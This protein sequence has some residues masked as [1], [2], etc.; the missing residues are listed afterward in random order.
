MPPLETGTWLDDLPDEKRPQEPTGQPVDT[1][2]WLDDLPDAKRPRQVAGE[3]QQ[4]M[5]VAR[6]GANLAEEPLGTFIARRSIPFYSTGRNVGEALGY[7]EARKRFAAGQQTDEDYRTVAEYERQQQLDQEREQTWGGSLAAGAAHLP[8]IVGEFAAGGAA[9][10]GA[11][12]AAPRA[13]GWLAPKVAEE[14]AAV[15]VPRLLSSEGL[16]AAA[17]ATPGY[18]GRTAALTPL[19]PSSYVDHWTQ[20]NV[21][22]GRDPLDVRGLPK[23]YGLGVMQ[24]AVLGAIGGVGQGYVKGAGVA[25]GLAR[26][27]IAGG[28]GATVAQPAADVL[29]YG[30]GLQTRYGTIQ[31]LVEGK[32]GDALRH[33]TVQ[34]L[35]F[36]AF[37]LAHEAGRRPP[38]APDPVMLAYQQKLQEMASRG[39]APG[40]AGEVLN[41][42]TDVLAKALEENPNLER[43]QARRAVE[44]M[45]A[46]PARE[47]GLEI[48]KGWPEHRG[49]TILPE[50][51]TPEQIEAA[52]RAGPTLPP[53]EP[54]G[55]NPF[56]RTPEGDL[57]IGPREGR[58]QAPEAPPG[59]EVPR[60]AP[61]ASPGQVGAPEGRQAA[62]EPAPFEGLSADEIQQLAQQLTGKKLRTAEGLAAALQ[63]HGLSEAGVRELADAFRPQ[64]SGP[65]GPDQSGPGRITSDLDET[66]KA[67]G[68]GP[69][70]REVPAAKSG[71]VESGSNW[72]EAFK[73]A[74]PDATPG[75]GG[76]LKG[77]TDTHTVTM[78]PGSTPDAV[79]IDFYR[80]PQP[81]ETYEQRR[82]KME[83][84]GA[85]LEP[86][87]LEVARR[88]YK[89]VKGLKE[90]GKRIEYVTDGHAQVYEQ[91]LKKLGYRQVEGPTEEG[92]KPVFRAWEPAG[93]AF[94]KEAKLPLTGE[95]LARAG[96]IDP[97]ALEEFNQARREY[98]QS[99]AADREAARRGGRGEASVQRAIE[100]DLSE[101]SAAGQAGAAD[102]GAGEPAA[103]HTAPEA[104][105]GLRGEAA[106]NELNRPGELMNGRQARQLKAKDAWKLDVPL[107]ALH[108]WAEEIYQN[109]QEANRHYN[110][111]L[112]DVIGSGSTKEFE[113]I[114]RR[115]TQ[116]AV[117]GKR[118]DPSK[119]PGFDEALDYAKRRYAH[120]DTE[121]KLYE[122]L[123]EGKRG[124]TR[125]ESYEQALKYLRDLKETA[126]ATPEDIAD[127]NKQAAR[128]GLS[129][130]PPEL[131]SQAEAEALAEGA[132]EEGPAAATGEAGG[133]ATLDADGNLRDESGNVLFGP[134]YKH[135]PGSVDL[136]RLRAELIAGLRKARGGVGLK[137]PRGLDAEPS[138]EELTGAAGLTPQEKH[139]LTQRV[140]QGRTF[141]EIARDPEMRKPDGRAPSEVLVLLRERQALAKFGLEGRGL[142]DFM[143]TAAEGRDADLGELGRKLAQGEPV[144][145]EDF[146]EAGGLTP[147]QRYVLR[148][149]AQGRTAVDIGRDEALPRARPGAA[150]LAK[151]SVYDVARQAYQKLG[152]LAEAWEEKFVAPA[153]AE[154][155]RQ[156]AAVRARQQQERDRQLEESARQQQA[157]AGR[158]AGLRRDLAEGRPVSAEEM[159]DLARLTP[160]QRHVLLERA[161]GRLTSEIGQD[162]ELSAEPLTGKAVAKISELAFEKLGVSADQWLSRFGSPGALEAARPQRER[163]G[164]LEELQRHMAEGRA[165]LVG[166]MLDAAGLKPV[167]KYVLR[168][169][170]RGRPLAHVAADAEMR[171]GDGSTYSW[172][173]MKYIQKVALEKLGR[174]PSEKPAVEGAPPE[175]MPPGPEQAG[176]PANEPPARRRVGPRVTTAATQEEPPAEPPRAPAAASTPEAAPQKPAVD[177]DRLAEFFGLNNSPELAEKVNG[178]TAQESHVLNERMTGRSLEKIGTDEAVRRDARR[179]GLRDKPLTREAVRQIEK[180]ALAKLG[181]D[182][183][184]APLPPWED[185][186]EQFARDHPDLDQEELRREYEWLRRLPPAE[187][188]KT[189]AQ[190]H[191]LE[192]I[193]NALVMLEKGRRSFEDLAPEDPETVG[194]VLQARYDSKRQAEEAFDELTERWLE[195]KAN[196]KLT[197]ESDARYQA[198]AARLFAQAQGRASEAAGQPALGAAATPGQSTGVLYGPAG[199]AQPGGGPGGKRVGPFEIIATIKRL[200]NLPTYGGGERALYDLRNESSTVPKVQAGDAPLATHEMA[201]HLAKILGLPLDPAAL[202]LNVVRGFRQF[203]YVKGRP[204]QAEAMQEGFAEWMRRRE[205]NQL[206]GLT[207]EQEA[208]SRHAEKMLA[209][210]PGV[211]EKL[212]RVKDLFTQFQQ[213]SPKDRYAGLISQTGMPAQPV[214]TPG[215]KAADY[216]GRV[217]QAANEN[218]LDD[219]AAARRAEAAATARGE[220]F[221]PGT[222]LS[223][224]MATTRLR[225][226]PDTNEMRQG[227]VFA[228]DQ[229][230]RHVRLGRPLKEILK[231]VP[232]EDIPD[233][234]VLMHARRDVH[235][236]DVKGLQLPPEQLRDAREALVQLAGDMPR[237][238]RLSQAADAIGK[239]VFDASL[240]AMVMAGRFSRE[241]VDKIKLENPLYAST[242]RVL[243]PENKYFPPGRRKGE[244]PRSATFLKE[245]TGESGEQR[246]GLM[247]AIER[248]YRF[249]ASVLNDQARFKAIYDLAK[250]EGV[251]QWLN[252]GVPGAG[253]EPVGWPLDGTK[254]S[255]T[256][257]IGG[258][259]FRI[260]INDRAFYEL[261]TGTQG[262]GGRAYGFLKG[263]GDVMQATH[264]PQAVRTGGTILSPLW[265]VKN[266]IRDPILYAQRTIA[267]KGTLGNLA[268]LFS[269]YGKSINFY[270]RALLA[271]GAENVE[272]RKETDHYFKL[273]EQMTGR[274]FSLGAESGQKTFASRVMDGWHGLFQRISDLLTAGE[275]GTR[276]LELK[277]VW[278]KLGWT[279]QKIAAELAKDPAQRNPVPFPVQVAALDI[280]SQITHNVHQ[281]GASIRQLNRSVPFLGAHIAGVYKDIATF[282]TQPKKVLGALSVL[283]AA[284]AAEWL[285]NKDDREW[286]EL[287]D[288]YRFGFSFKTPLG[289]MHL[290]APRGL[291]GIVTGMMDNAQ[292][293]MSQSNPRFGPLMAQA[294]EEVA[295]RAGPLGV[296]FQVAGNRG[297]TGRPIIPDREA[298][299]M[300]I[301][302]RFVDPRALQYQAS[303]LTGGMI[304]PHRLSLN[305]FAMEQ[306]PHQSVTDFWEKLR[307]LES[308]S[309]SDPQRRLG[310]AFPQ[311][312]EF[313][314]LK[315]VEPQMEA[316]SRALRGE[317]HVGSRV[318]QGEK[319]TP[320]REAELRARQTD[321]ARRA[322][323][324]AG[325]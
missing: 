222:R 281:M 187:V 224:V 189:A 315:A 268:D 197:P 113:N 145:M 27:G 173:N 156:A 308:A 74:F 114:A 18:L 286:Q 53:E 52:R 94:L 278:D 306:H 109:S 10:R 201:H 68:M 287:P 30:A 252:P 87:S 19:V 45:P 249:T 184:Q 42:A 6:A 265:H 214:I 121:E 51:A 139:V 67:L 98:E 234:E 237:F 59:P 38:G 311:E 25:P 203:D 263:L 147:Q 23:A 73:A 78:E 232:A 163:A 85:K 207:P 120:L 246:I 56:P 83:Q 72:A 40:R 175:E 318:V 146:F 117:Q 258:E 283:A 8:A 215:E 219:V 65:P 99:L 140:G 160:Q 267:D 270:A 302:Q 301:G 257:Y 138:L 31:E 182:E 254:P 11:A 238:N 294:F 240:D 210:K 12:G 213:Q 112:E 133:G 44:A 248:R 88:L 16:K 137:L 1:G 142:A 3:Q 186:R 223:E 84:V 49:L 171:R 233:L 321:L 211:V 309:A 195:D 7:A 277:N 9:L 205:T 282:A 71:Q 221:A 5:E 284:K 235:D 55:P 208:A 54:E 157:R 166:Q 50:D 92:S 177:V 24:L 39:V 37:G 316:L 96:R 299:R 290:P 89:V 196:G 292:R 272:V 22:E 61:G 95:E 324:A 176:P 285:L 199:A 304:D 297:W 60:Q 273:M 91:A 81:G 204:N 128:P 129:P 161:R 256:G 218:Y 236:A 127:V 48:V 193:E 168:E 66:T 226:I 296:P 13:L 106:G 21:Q 28:V 228:Y 174:P 178:L 264:V 135:G 243:D 126:R 172:A 185:V 229:D 107:D 167:E 275:K 111:A 251:G 206:F 76:I 310:K 97:R 124:I 312:R 130:L 298:D 190:R 183:A 64:Q 35:T 152:P 300:G 179:A 32:Y 202:P 170:A 188:R 20:Q 80:N 220:K 115:L 100:R 136:G 239:E 86:G 255:V 271:R 314:R 75:A 15:A 34:A 198:E 242:Q 155:A 260:R 26:L 149:R 280:A 17:R 103:A 144:T 108:G 245:R 200:F 69:A 295:P 276:V 323:E 320:Q 14:G 261:V 119:I 181:A 46:G 105:P 90:Q 70:V 194:R 305:P 134:R 165:D 150:P 102:E 269:W 104:A 259:P 33:A 289:W 132:G 125:E 322:L 123:K 110:D 101:A 116:N 325:R 307:Q 158:L 191:E 41:G 58:P 192:R 62:A 274:E 151:E 79:K 77:K 2:T 313:K 57:L 153:E 225:V 148:E 141:R 293:A 159:M 250:R 317:R 131:V 169:R 303:Q 291:T 4:K 227:G 216:V 154:R 122:S 288:H 209:A 162:Q 231:D 241:A 230:G 43:D 319:P 247:E 253:G 217:A 164:R 279:Q 212:D 36:A 63:R 82:D 143:T 29:A 47:W 180:K 118:D 266:F 244:E 93:D 262:E